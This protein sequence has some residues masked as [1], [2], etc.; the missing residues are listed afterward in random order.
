MQKRRIEPKRAVILTVLGLALA[1]LWS[2]CG[3]PPPV[4]PAVAPARTGAE[5]PQTECLRATCDYLI[6]QQTPSGGLTHREA[7]W[8]QASIAVRAWLGAYRVLGDARYLAAAERTL[9]AFVSEQLYNGGWCVWAW[10]SVP[11]ERRNNFSTADLGSMAACLSIAAPYVS[12]EK[13]QRYIAAHRR[14]VEQFLPPCDLKGAAFSAG[15]VDGNLLEFP[16]TTATAT[17]ALS[18]LALYQ[19][20][21]ERVYRWRAEGAVRYMISDWR[22][23]GRAPFHPHDV[24]QMTYLMATQF[25][26]LYYMLEALL[27]MYNNTADEEL[28]GAIRTVLLNYVW[29]DKGLFADMES[30]ID[31]VLAERG[32]AASKARGMPAILCGIRAALGRAEG[33][34]SLIDRSLGAL[35][36]MPD[37]QALEP[38]DYAF[39]ALSLAEA[40]DPHT[41]VMGDRGA[42]APK[43]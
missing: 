21:G 31:W 9:D 16:Y 10:E 32:P 35:C 18:F 29:G 39:V 22:D 33:L 30:G 20:T 34:D 12:P 2:A 6:A 42:A 11:W 23:D 17:Q 43:P 24:Y 4:A 8:W 7:C 27:W 40:L 3:P 5:S 15:W 13:A 1:G 26:N 41:N 37:D 14:Y 38:I 36:P 19:A 25:H 28:Q